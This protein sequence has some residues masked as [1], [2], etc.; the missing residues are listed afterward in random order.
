[1]LYSLY[2]FSLDVA[3]TMNGLEMKQWGWGG[4]EDEMYYHIIL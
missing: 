4:D 1:L 2:L 3:C